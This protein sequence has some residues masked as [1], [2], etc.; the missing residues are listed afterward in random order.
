MATTSGA[1][2]AQQVLDELKRCKV[3]H[4]VWLPD[5]EARFMYDTIMGDPAFTLVPVCR[6]GEAIPIAVG[7]M[8][9]ERIP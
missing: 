9:G 8:L 2:R 4:I 7:L 5:S 3:T 6:E 1:L